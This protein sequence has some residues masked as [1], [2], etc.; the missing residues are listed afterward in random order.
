MT[1][2]IFLLTAVL[3]L[4]ACAKSDDAPVTP[5]PPASAAEV[6]DILALGD[7]Y[8]KGESVPT[9]QNFPHQLADSLRARGFDVPKP[10]H[11]I[12]QTGWRTDQL[13]AAYNS[14]TALHDSTFSLVTL[15]IGVNNQYQN[16]N[17]ETYKAEFGQLLQTAIARAGDRRDRVVVLSIPDWAYTPYGQNYPGDPQLISQKIDQYNA[18]NRAIT[19]QYEVAYVDVTGISRRGLD[20]PALV[21]G[22][23]LHPSAKQYTEWVQALL[24]VAVNLL[25]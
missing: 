19:D 18:A 20:E 17:F 23:G 8:T 24:P 14:Q 15:L 22:D 12:A 5:E 11:V 10:P 7:S 9:A 25:R 13:R 16:A 1:L 4:A 2:Q 6:I 3:A 21:A